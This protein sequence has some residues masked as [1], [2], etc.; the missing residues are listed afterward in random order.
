[1][2]LRQRAITVMPM[3]T[4]LTAI[5]AFGIGF[6]VGWAL[7][8]ILVSWFSVTFGVQLITFGLL[9]H[10]AYQLKFALVTAVL[11][12]LP[13]LAS[14]FTSARPSISRS[15]VLWLLGTGCSTLFAFYLHQ[16]Y[17]TFLPLAL[18]SPRTDKTFVSI[19]S[20]PL[21]RIPISGIACILLAAAIFKL[22]GMR[23]NQQ[24]TST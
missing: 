10:S 13:A 22:A 2:P 9:E 18:S 1:M 21:F 14:R 16:A 12:A 24:T 4:R 15:L 3:N 17:A 19:E 6:I 23:R 20:L 8:P 11:F 7:E 5:V